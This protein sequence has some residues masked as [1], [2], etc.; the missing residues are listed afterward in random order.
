MKQREQLEIEPVLNSK[1]PPP[2]KTSANKAIPPKSPKQCQGIK[3]S[4][5]GG[6]GQ[7]LPFEPLQFPIV[8]HLSLHWRQVYDVYLIGSRMSLGASLS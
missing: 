6:G 7:A 3:C 5:T 1:S 4:N 8:K 2:V